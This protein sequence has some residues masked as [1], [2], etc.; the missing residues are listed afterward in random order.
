MSLIPSTSGSNSTSIVRPA[1]L[2][3]LHRFLVALRLLAV[4]HR[5]GREHLRVAPR[6]LR[7]RLGILLGDVVR[8]EP[9]RRVR[10]EHLAPRA[11]LEPLVSA[12]PH[13]DLA[14]GHE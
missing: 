9:R 7:D 11:P 3:L 13:L 4:D 6:R 12:R 10:G 2:L 14:A 1:M 8:A 5:E